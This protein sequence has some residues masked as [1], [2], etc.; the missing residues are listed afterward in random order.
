MVFD[1]F[2]GSG[3]V[4][5][6]SMLCGINSVGFDINPLA[7]LISRVKTTVFKKG[8]VKLI[9]ETTNTILRDSAKVVEGGGGEKRQS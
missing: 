7:V 2:M 6:E 8:A 3:G 9:A 5:L 1:P 4:L